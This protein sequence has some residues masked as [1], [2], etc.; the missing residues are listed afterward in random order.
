MMTVAAWFIG[1]GGPHS[2]L[3][4]AG[5]QAERIS[6]LWWKYFWISIGVYVLTMIGLLLAVWGR[7]R[8]QA[9]VAGDVPLITPEP[10]G[11]RRRII[12]VGAL[13]TVSA[14]ILFYLMVNEFLTARALG[15]LGTETNPLTIKVIGRQ[16][17]W[18]VQYPDLIPSN[19]VTT[20]N[21]I[22]VPTGRAI[23]VQLESH[24]VIHSFWIPNL[25][26]KKD[27]IPGHPTSIWIKA[28][29]AGTYVGQCAEFCGL[30]HAH[31]RLVAVV[32]SP[33]KFTNW[34]SDAKQ[35]ASPPQTENAKRGFEVFMSK[36]CVMCHT[37]NGTPASGMVGPNLTHLARRSRIA[38]NSFPANRGYLAGWILNP[39]H[40][41]PGVRMPQHN[42]SAE[43]LHALLDYLETLK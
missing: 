17:W 23:Q 42:L 5:P 16:W 38:A 6:H 13:V 39:Q 37:I 3:D 8:M 33:E 40:L 24:D 32:E 26:G 15:S 43:E 30:Q 19:I 2:A 27:L 10:G 29:K 20:A 4:P 41:K 9:A 36:T 34:L 31:M 1:C 12:I 28:D 21:E 14:G 22:H 18:E 11:E 35:L 25:H 7:R